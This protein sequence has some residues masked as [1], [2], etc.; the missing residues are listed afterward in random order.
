LFDR[1][2]VDAECSTDGSLKHL[3]QKIRKSIANRSNDSVENT[4]IE[5][6]TL[7]KKDKL[8]E[9]VN[10]QRKLILSGFRL[11]KSGGVMVYSTCSL[12]KE[13]NEDV[14]SWL[15]EEV[16]PNAFILPV[17]FPDASATSIVKEG[18]LEGTVRFKPCVGVEC[19]TFKV[20]GG[21]FFL[22]KLGKL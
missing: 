15:L 17:S 21:G 13:Q 3:E 8:S 20:Y 5:N 10:L 7:E 9:L 18:F 19:S 6:E 11:L 16:K 12:S 4:L 2:L 22:A 14:V 1:V